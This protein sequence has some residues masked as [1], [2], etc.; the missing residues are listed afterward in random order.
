MTILSD[1]IEINAVANDA[2]IVVERSLCNQNL[3]ASYSPTKASI[4]VLA[5]IQKA[6]LPEATQEIRAINLFGNYGSG[7]SHLAVLIAQLC[8]DGS[9]S[10]EFSDFFQR[11][12]NFDEAKLAQDLKNTFPDDEDARPYLLVS[13]YGAEAPT[14]GD[15]LME[16]LYDAL[17]RHPD[18]DPKAILPTTEYEIAVQSFEQMVEN[19]PQYADTDLSEWR[20]AQDYV[21]TAEMLTGLKN[22][23]S[24][25]LDVFR[26]WYKAVCHGV[27]IFNPADN[28]GKNFITAYLEAG[29]NLAEQHQ[30]GGII[31]I[32]DE[33]GDA[34][35]NLIGHPNRN[36]G[37]E[38]MLLQRFVETVCKPSKGHT[39]F[40]GLT[41]V[42]FP[43]YAVRTSANDTVKNRLEAIS[44][45]FN[46][47]F[48]MELSAVECEGYHL[49]G[50]Q[51]SWT[52][53]GKRYLQDVQDARQ[54]LLESCAHLLL[55]KELG[56]H[57]SQV[58][59]ECYP[60]HPI[61]AAGLFALSDY[62][63]SNRTALTFFRDNADKVLHRE[64]SGQGLFM[65]E[66]I[67][68]PELVDYYADRLKEKKPADWERYQRA[69]AK[70]PADLP[71]DKIQSRQSI[72]KLLFLAPLLGENF[73]TTESF[74]ASSLYDAKPNTSAAL[75][76]STD[77]AWLKTA[78]L[79]WKHDVTEQWLL[80]SDSGVDVE[81]LITPKLSYF[82][83]RSPETLFNDH[84]EMQEDLLPP[85]GIHDLDPSVCGIV[86][87]YQI[88]LLTP[89]FSNQVKISDP[90][91]SG[92]VF[93]VL[94]KDK[95]EVD[96]VKG[97]IQETSPANLYFWLPLAGIRAEAV[98]LD[99][100][101]FRLSGLLC[102]YLALELL[103]K[104][105]T[106][107]EDLRRQLMAKWEKCRQQLLSVLKI[108]FGREGLESGK[109]Q[110][111]KAGSADPIPCQSWHD[112]KRI[113]AVDI[114][115]TY[116]Q[117][118][119]VR[120]MNL[121]KLNVEK[122][123]GS[124][125]VLKIVERILDFADNPA[126]QTDLLGEPK[127]SSER[128]ALIDGVLGANQLFIERA[129]GV[130]IKK[131]DETEGVV[132]DMLILIH[133]TLVHKRE[134][135]YLVS[136]LRDKL[137]A[138]PYGLPS[139]T[140]AMFA[141]VAVR[142]DTKRLRFGST[143]EEDFARNLT[144]AFVQDSK[145]TLRLLEFTA[146]QFAMLFGL[147]KHFNLEKISTQTQEE[148]AGQ[149]VQTLRQFVLKQSEAV[150]QSAL[151]QDKTKNLV[152]FLSLPGKN[153]QDV[154]E[155]LL[156]LLALDREI[157]S[158][159]GIKSQS[160]LKTLLDDFAK[161]ENAK[162]YEIKQTLQTVVPKNEGDKQ[163]LLG[164]LNHPSA[165]PQAKAVAEL[166]EQHDHVDDIAI[167]KVTQVFLDKPFEQCSDLEIGRCQG[168]LESLINHHQQPL[169]DNTIQ[170]PAVIVAA[171]EL[172]NALQRWLKSK[173]LAPET[174]RSA[175]TAVLSEY[176]G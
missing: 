175:L 83:G 103:L 52:E 167:T 27:A 143:K 15:Q 43:E 17:N 120:A 108:L 5:H 163:Q 50:M 172:I 129:D 77:L 65:E 114:Q 11:L 73:Q 32:W 49:L 51:K 141:A 34:L 72:L 152:K 93:L 6:V 35:E 155:F 128:S 42:S 105:K 9:G 82:A 78:E 142:N 169:T 70:I 122:Y 111:F 92:Q 75:A 39:L 113:L 104:E 144:D 59:S 30:F 149:C 81:A 7:K 4:A 112:F 135:P 110:V 118:I 130:D 24:L 134:K 63:Q 127:E 58:L 61:M 36:A 74:L 95:E 162:Q 97:R 174:I 150:K 12:N 47:P 76:L 170:E 68:L 67:R 124:D 80:F 8:R 23:Q 60:L 126:Y 29:K 153:Q 137:I 14:L 18:L 22:H 44:G 21:T 156:E 99:G 2:A 176:G 125:K 10:T 62:A 154:A 90:L 101:E 45:R 48:K 168:Q 98:E 25:A 147:G 94:A 109:S 57:F 158:D 139:C 119:P 151:L 37:D 100:K 123:T 121:N 146:K 13:L 3:V 165:P 41:H 116:P 117:E 133:K 71:R 136:E 84:P 115:N 87:S 131:I 56:Q 16:G 26:Q 102:R 19:S 85:I 157:A 107:S 28:G 171:D 140:L 33:F 38:I 173:S 91:L 161:V 132:K 54:Q 55:F 79:C 159:I 40:I 20:L 64:L 96:I 86:R 1:I 53:L 106:A 88:N 46:K 148:Y 166:L 66:L 31:V 160:L 164:R 145:I 89:P 69:A 138:P